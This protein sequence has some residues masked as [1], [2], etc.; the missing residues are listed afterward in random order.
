MGCCPSSQAITDIYSLDGELDVK[1]DNTEFKGVF[2]KCHFKGSVISRRKNLQFEGRLEYMLRKDG[3]RRTLTLTGVFTFQDYKMKGIGYINP[4]WDIYFRGFYTIFD[5]KGDIK[6]EEGSLNGNGKKHGLITVTYKDGNIKVYQYENGII[7][8]V[9]H[10][11]KV[12]KTRISQE[13]VR[14]DEIEEG[15]EYRE[16]HEIEVKMLSSIQLNTNP[17]LAARKLSPN[18]LATSME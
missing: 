8:Q 13:W 14:L 16:D 6:I 17:A 4:L 10:I 5:H 18:E 15:R 11:V 3:L 1:I 9:K 12:P 2:N 7:K